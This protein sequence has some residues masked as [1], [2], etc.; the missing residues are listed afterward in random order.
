VDSQTFVRDP[1]TYGLPIERRRIERT[2]PERYRGWQLAWQSGKPQTLSVIEFFDPE[3]LRFKLREPH[4]MK[5]HDLFDVIAPSLN[6]NIH[7]NTITGCQQPVT[8]TSHGS[9]TSFFRNNLIERG[10]A[11]NATQAIVVTG[12]FKLDGNHIA[13]FDEKTTSAPNKP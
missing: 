9:D 2:G 7:D 11:T 8:L 1:W 5:V 13:G 10:G 3:T 6:W 4:P 12:R